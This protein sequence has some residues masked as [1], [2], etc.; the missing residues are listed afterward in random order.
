MMTGYRRSKIGYFTGKPDQREFLLQKGLNAPRK[1]G[2][3]VNGGRLIDKMK[4][5]KLTSYV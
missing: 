2:Y 3:G 5:R 1:F 4:P